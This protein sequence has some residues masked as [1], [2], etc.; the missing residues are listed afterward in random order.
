MM[1]RVWA[2]LRRRIVVTATA[3]ALAV[4][5][6]LL[7]C[8]S[9]LLKADAEDH[10]N[11]VS[12]LTAAVMAERLEEPLS[13]GD[14]G[15]VLRSAARNLGRGGAAAVSVFDRD[16]R[17][18]A[19][20]PSE[21][22]TE[23]PLAS[24][25]ADEDARPRLALAGSPVEAR[26]QAVRRGGDVVGGFWIAMD[27]R[28]LAEAR[29]RFRLAALATLAGA[30]SLSWLISWLLAGQLLRPLEEFGNTVAEIGRGNYATRHPVQGPEEIRKLARRINKMAEQL[31]AAAAEQ[32][33][34]A[35]ESGQQLLERTRQI[36]QANR[37]LRDIANKDPLT[38]LHN[39]L[40]LEMEMEKYLS[41]CRR[42]GQ[43]LAVIMMDLDS[44]KAYN[45][46]RGHAAGDTALVTVAAAL[47]ARSR[48]SDVVAR[49][50]GDEF[51]IVIPF[52]KPER[53]VAA[54]EGFVS[55]VVDATLDL[56]RLDS[57]AQ[58]GAS[59][60]VAC[61]PADGDEG[62]E[63]LARADAALY[64]AKAAG[65]GRVFRASPQEPAPQ[66]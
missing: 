52:T 42:S 39:R 12:L 38:Q 11:R 51:C 48:A 54:A 24:W 9:A 2:S 47:K 61:F 35:A 41:L 18:V 58:L 3:S 44:F 6:L 40:G 17:R 14:R 60:G 37:L 46:T 28:P 50:G 43:P 27:R 5:L 31:E 22:G 34:S 57:G 55:A 30:L 4:T 16:R 64:R 1:S 23:P 8:V 19:T 15:A 20:E 32:A 13:S 56:P 45:D 66:A 53:A 65:K 25:P 63:L 49:L 7:A 33:R 21:A 62:A 26:F 29:T 59:A 36:E 10:F